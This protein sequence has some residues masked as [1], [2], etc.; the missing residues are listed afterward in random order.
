M[1]WSK[2]DYTSKHRKGKDEEVKTK[3]CNE[4]IQNKRRITQKTPPDAL[5]SSILSKLIMVL[6]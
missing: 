5:E 4:K 2:R 6:M 3:A 1:S